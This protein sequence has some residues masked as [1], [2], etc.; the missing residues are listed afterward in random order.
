MLTQI[1]HDGFKKHIIL[2]LHYSNLARSASLP[3]GLYILRRV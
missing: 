1:S 3:K 2:H